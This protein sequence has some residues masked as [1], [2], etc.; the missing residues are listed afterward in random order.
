VAVSLER[1]NTYAAENWRCATDI[2][3]SAG[4]SNGSSLYGAPFDRLFARQQYFDHQGLF[5]T[6]IVGV[7]LLC[8]MLV[9]VVCPAVYGTPAHPRDLT[10]D[11]LPF[12]AIVLSQVTRL[13]VA[14]G[15]AKVKHREKKKK[16]AVA[17]TTVGNKKED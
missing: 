4:E 9:V 1:I 17:D 2:W 11:P 15:R 7:P 13:L 3:R 12:K 14:A 5:I 8:N 6:L 16:E 10:T